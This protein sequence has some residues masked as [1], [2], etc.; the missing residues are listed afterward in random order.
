[1]Y[2]A[3][4]IITLIVAALVGT[5]IGNLLQLRFFMDKPVMKSPFIRY[6]SLIVA[7]IIMINIVPEPDAQ[8][9]TTDLM[10]YGLWWV[11]IAFLVSFVRPPTPLKQAADPETT[12]V[13]EPDTAAPEAPEELPAAPQEE[14]G[15][16]QQEDG[17]DKV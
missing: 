15:A 9:S 2:T 11:L 3:S 4:G 1:M 6:G 16:G 7:I 5:L 14:T 10:G 12:E 13:T 17:S 8:L